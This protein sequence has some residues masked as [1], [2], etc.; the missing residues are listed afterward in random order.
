MTGPDDV[1]DHPSD[2]E[3]CELDEL[4]AAE[5][6]GAKNGENDDLD[7]GTAS[8]AQ[9]SD[10]AHE[11]VT[12]DPAPPDDPN[13]SEDEDEADNDDRG[14]DGEAANKRRKKADPLEDWDPKIL[15]GTPSPP[16][17]TV[18][19]LSRHR[20]LP[21]ALTEHWARPMVSCARTTALTTP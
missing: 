11:A 13:M 12:G 19:P 14:S 10:P 15:N 7:G 18:G 16:P 4:E 21:T 9:E 8:E 6:E 5:A 20:P 17:C 1:W 2:A 3:E